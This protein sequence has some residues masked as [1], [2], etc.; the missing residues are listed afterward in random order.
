MLLLCQVSYHWCFPQLIMAATS[1]E[2]PIA[3]YFG[4][5]RLG[6]LLPRDLHAESS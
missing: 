6:S 4:V 3:L 2:H 5:S 1:K